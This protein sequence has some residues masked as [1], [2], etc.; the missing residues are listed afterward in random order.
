[1]QFIAIYTFGALMHRGHSIVGGGR[2][3]VT[4]IFA[5]NGS[6]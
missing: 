1:M 2:D 4:C 3:I 6:R 5:N